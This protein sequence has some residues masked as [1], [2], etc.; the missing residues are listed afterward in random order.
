MISDTVLLLANAASTLALFGLIWTI[1]LV[2]YPT[3]L[4]IAPERFLQ[5][6]AFHQRQISFVV[7]PLMVVELLSTLYLFFVPP[8]ILPAWCATIGVLLLAII[9]TSTFLIQVPLHNVLS[10]GYDELTITRLVRSNWIRT[11]AW[12]LRSAVVLWGLWCVMAAK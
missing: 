4:H 2:H 10:K 8:A 7:L 11:I 1:Q 3:F 12:S 6:E 9:W 5:F